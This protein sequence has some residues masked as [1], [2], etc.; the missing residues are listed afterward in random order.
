MHAHSSAHHV[1][2]KK[3]L[4]A[5]RNTYEWKGMSAQVKRVVRLCTSR[6]LVGLRRNL[7]HG[8]FSSLQYEGPRSAFA[9]D[10][11]GV[12][13]SAEGHE[14][15]L[16]V[17]DLFSREVQFIPLFTRTAEEVLKTLLARV[18]FDKGVPSVF[19]SDEA[20]EFVG[21]LMKG[22]CSA[23]GIKQMTTKAYN[24][25]GNSICETVHKFL[26]SCLTS[27][28]VDQRPAWPDRLQE[29]AFAHNTTEH[30]S[31]QCTPF[32][33]TPGTKARTLTDALVISGGQ[34]LGTDD[35]AKGY[36]GELRQRAKSY[37][38][39]AKEAL[40]QATKEQNARLNHGSFRRTFAV[41]DLVSIYFPRRSTDATWKQKHMIQW[42]GPMR[43][44][45]RTSPTSYAM[46]DVST[47]QRFERTVT[48]VNPYHAPLVAVKATDPTLVNDSKKQEP[49]LT[50][51]NVVPGG[52][53]AVRDDAG[54]EEWWLA[55]RLTA[56]AEDA[57]FHYWGTSNAKPDTAIFKPAH[58]GGRTGL[59]ILSHN[60]RQ[61]DGEPTTAWT[62][63][64][65][66]DLV[67]GPVQL[68]RD[69]QGAHRLTAAS[70]RMVAQWTMAR[71]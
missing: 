55:E 60:P 62:G 27:L 10:F 22:L 50:E 66:P 53:Y 64:L 54:A 25:R 38:D 17:I 18:I 7:K 57:T 6:P 63:V 48:N 9:F 37:H 44:I 30:D 29:F 35:D 32:E 14:W 46:E 69:K 12:A 24:P 41:G 2:W 61:R 68:R 19:M 11:Y 47:G 20:P 65:G 40:R 16:T 59:T 28:P 51:S 34:V 8:Q 45:E 56:D 1:K 58:I 71:L 70:R 3:V 26:G 23:L 13:R 67:I 43:V 31:I 52:M 21:K 49:E 42:R 15:I 36:Y 4:V 5:L 33:I 39:L